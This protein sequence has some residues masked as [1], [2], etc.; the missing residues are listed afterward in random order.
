MKIYVSQNGHGVPFNITTVD[1]LGIQT[2]SPYFASE[3]AIISPVD[4][5][6]YYFTDSDGN[7][8]VMKYG[9]EL[10]DGMTIELPTSGSTTG[11]GGKAFLF[12]AAALAAL[13]L[14]HKRK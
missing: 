7:N 4:Y 1:D 6:Y 9:D 13:F 3:E 14:I 2:M 8:S 11:S 10:T 12:V 5:Y